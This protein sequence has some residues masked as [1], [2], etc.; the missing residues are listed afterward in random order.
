MW[1]FRG[2]DRENYRETGFVPFT[3]AYYGIY[4]RSGLWRWVATQ[5]LNIFP[6]LGVILEMAQ[7]VSEGSII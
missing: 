4:G 1:S 7:Y 5:I 3:G 2:K 6:E